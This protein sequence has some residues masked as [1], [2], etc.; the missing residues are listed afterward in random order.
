[1]HSKVTNDEGFSALG[2]LIGDMGMSSAGPP[3]AARSPVVAVMP[4][5]W[6]R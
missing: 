4:M 1:M 6:E 5:H 2:G 3:G